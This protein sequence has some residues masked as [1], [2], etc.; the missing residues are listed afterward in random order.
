MCGDTQSLPVRRISCRPLN[1]ALLVAGILILIIVIIFIAYKRKSRESDR[2]MKRMQNQMD[3]LE[4]KVAKECKEGAS[5]AALRS[6]LAADGASVASGVCLFV[7]AWFV[8][9][10]CH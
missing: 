3:A 5:R 9:A 10:C 7:A 2:V 6:R 8:G 1:V 4:A